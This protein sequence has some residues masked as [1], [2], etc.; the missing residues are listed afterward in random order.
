M[1]STAPRSRGRGDQNQGAP[2]FHSEVFAQTFLS[3]QAEVG[4]V[5]GARQAME[6]KFNVGGLCSCRGLVH[7][8]ELAWA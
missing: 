3:P 5:W 2:P 8:G 6:T 4:R 1:M 7:M